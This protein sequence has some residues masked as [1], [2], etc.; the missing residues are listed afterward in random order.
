MVRIYFLWG[1]LALMLFAGQTQAQ[2]VQPVRFASGAVF[3][4]ENYEQSLQNGVFTPDEL[5]NGYY[6]R[7]LQFPN[8]LTEAQRRR[9]ED[10]GAK[11][12]GYVRF[13]AYL[14]ALPKQFDLKD[15]GRWG[16]RSIITPK[17][18]W[19]TA[20]N[21]RE[22]PFNSW[23]VH[24]DEIDV[25][26]QIYPHVGIEQGAVLCA[27]A[28]IKVLKKG[29]QNG[30]LSVRIAQSDI[31]KT[32]MLPFIQYMEQVA[33]PGK[34]EDTR[35][36]S[37]HRSNL[38]DTEHAGG[39]K[40]N[41]EGV[42][43]LV[44]DDGQVGPHIDYQGRLI[45][46]A[47]TAPQVGSHG[48]GVGGIMAGA[49]NLNPSMRG[50]ATGAR[51]F[52]T[53]YE[54]SFQDTTLWLFKN[55]NV[56]ITNSSYSD[57]CNA[58]YTLASQTV[59]K[60][61]FENP[62]LM[63]VFS[64]G[65]ANGAGDC[66]YG[67]GSQWGNI[68][69]GHKQSKNS[70]ATANLFAD[71]SLVASSSRG[72]AY[73]GRMKP[74]IAA[75]GQ[76]QNSTDYNNDYQVFGGTSG[77]APGIAG[78]L[79]QLTHAYKTLNGGQEP[80]AAL[81]KAT[82]LNTANDLG[83]TGPDYRF[84]WGHVNTFAA[85]RTLETNRWRFGSIAQGE[86]KT[87]TIQIPNNTRFFRV[88]IY[89]A[90]PPAME[91]ASQALLNDLDLTVKSP[92]GTVNLPWKL[93]PE[94]DSAILALPAGKGRDSLNNVEQVAITAP[95][96][97]TYTVTIQGTEIPFGPQEY[98][99]VWETFNDAVKL[100]YPNGGEGFAP[101]DTVRIHWDA[102]TNTSNFTLRYSVDNGTTFLPLISSLN[103]AMRQ[104]DWKLPATI[105][106]DQV[107]FLLIRGAFRDTTD[108]A[109]TIAPS[110]KNVRVAKACPDSLAL[111]WD[112]IND[113]LNYRAYLLGEKYM[114]SVGVAIDTNYVIFPIKDPHLE[115][116]LAVAPQP[117]DNPGKRT[118][119]I[120]WPGGLRGCP[121]P[122]DMALKPSGALPGAI[123]RC[124]A[125]EQIISVQ[126]RN[127][128]Q[129]V[130]SAPTLS[131]QINNEAPV[132]ETLADILPGDT[133]IYNFKKT[134]PLNANTGTIDLKIWSGYPGDDYL[135]NDTI[136][137][138][139]VV[140]AQSSGPYLEQLN[141]A[142][143]PPSGW[144]V[145]NPDNLATWQRSDTITGNDGRPT[146]A[147]WLNCFDYDGRG[148][149]D[150]LYTIPV[151]LTTS[152]KPVFQFDL[153][154]AGYDSTYNDQ[155]RV[156][157]L[158]NCDITGTPIEVW[159][160]SYPDLGTVPDQTTQFFPFNRNNWRTETI[161]LAN[162]IGQ[163]LIIRFVA[164]NDFGNDMFIDNVG[165]VEAAP[166]VADFSTSGTQVCRNDTL[167][168]QVPQP[169]A[170][171]T[172]TWALGSGSVPTS[173]N[174][175]GPGPHYIRYTS[176]GTKNIRLIARNPFGAD[177]ITKTIEV[178]GPVT[179][180]FTAKPNALV[181]TFTYSGVNA[182]AFTWNFGD[183]ATSNEASPVHT[184]AAAGTYTV[185]LKVSGLCGTAERTQTV[186]V[187]TVGTA[188]LDP[189]IGFAVTPNPN[190]GAFE[191]V[192]ES[193]IAAALQL[194]LLDAQG[195]LVKSTPVEVKP[196]R[197][198][199]PFTGLQLPKGIYQLQA[200]NET[201]S[202]TLQV[203]V[204]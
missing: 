200:Q 167:V 63:H 34:P 10:K 110:V 66:G 44:R 151:D 45:N 194:N 199:I 74:D 124:E 92:N 181:T 143:F 85:L 201:G 88:M 17:F 202:R 100:V 129:N 122:E 149:E 97:G 142:Q 170:G 77:A 138:R 43:M 19:K 197:Q 55:E 67:A 90:E 36:K 98:Y 204:Q 165:I 150:F 18:E 13:G 158:T 198:T 193:G 182:T 159:N 5:Q 157:V 21:L 40:Y 6:V 162:F 184:Y 46:I 51:L 38:L 175:G 3:F 164:T 145:F 53:D 141:G 71:A 156:E 50:M 56:T 112:K 86:A 15:L 116:W 117:K 152:A 105:L 41:G 52:A 25:N 2:Q 64:A 33:P 65:N 155:L 188:D 171:A 49:G 32:A 81:L 42:S 70:I 72:P 69:G 29:N 27:E 109:C 20:R 89:W 62:T 160:K 146:T 57:G 108:F 9:M 111:T 173:S 11:V 75:N 87:H 135:F 174:V 101:G 61:L 23:A 83:T 187:T 172:Y 99:L 118:N 82:I 60:Q 80:P 8:V 154:H 134:V 24:G 12:L 168:L 126:V 16:L 94:P 183:G 95:A 189:R 106:S 93:N 192:F 37:L 48:D 186:A 59:D 31:E 128:G 91:N 14:T 133:L 54:N 176:V 26:L 195:R 148:E 147:Y 4:P 114:D 79:G 203:V 107:R 35:G 102:Y 113:T 123:V 7:Y 68:T 121:Q 179:A 169:Q 96:S 180:A 76:D 140:V 132:S 84:G 137:T 1:C 120:R 161:D 104:F 39:R 22:R 166:P 191:A 119:A 163:R 177:T 131:Y 103:P 47:T 190:N 185:T 28:G 127:D 196:G 73:D 139:I 30:F 125:G 178:L 130:L 144:S 115:K 58:G 153:A 78:C 136:R